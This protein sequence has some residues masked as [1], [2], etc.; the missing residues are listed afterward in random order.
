MVNCSRFCWK[1]ILSSFLP[2]A[3]ILGA[4]IFFI[5]HQESTRQVDHL[6]IHERSIA[7]ITTMAVSMELDTLVLSL[8]FLS[9]HEAL[10]SLR[11]KDSKFSIESLS[12]E[13]TRFLD[14]S[15][16][17]DQVKILDLSG[18]E[19]LRVNHSDKGSYVVQGSELQDKSG[20]EYFQQA[21]S[22][23]SSQIYISGMDL[24]IEQGRVKEPFKP[25][26]RA[27]V[28]ING[29]D[30]R[31]N[32][33]LV[34]IYF[35]QEIL[36]K[37]S[38]VAGEA[39]EKIM[40]LNSD[41]Q[42]FLGGP[43]GCNWSFMFPK[44]D[45]CYFDQRYPGDWGKIITNESG[46]FISSNG[47]FTFESIRMPVT[48][49]KAAEGN[50]VFSNRDWKLVSYV[51]M[52]GIWN[53]ST[54]PYLIGATSYIFI[55]LV[56]GFVSAALFRVKAEQDLVVESLHENEHRLREAEKIANLGSWEYDYIT[57]R[58]IWSDQTFRIFGYEPGEVKP[59]WLRF[60]K[61]VV[62]DDRQETI[63]AVPP[64]SSINAINLGIVRKDGVKCF[65]RVKR[66]LIE[67]N[68]KVV[69]ELGTIHDITEI[70]ERSDELGRLWR[71]IEHCPASIVITDDSGSVQYINPYFTELT[72]YS[73]SD[74]LGKNP[75]ILQ[76]GIHTK[77]FYLEMWSVLLS[78]KIWKGE[79]C[80][81]KK[82]GGIFWESATIAP[83]V[84]HRGTTTHYIGI[85]EDITQKRK[86]DEILRVSLQ[87]F[88]AL[89]ENSSIGI[90]Y[91][92]SGRSFHRVNNRFCDIVGY[93]QDDL[94]G[95]S[96]QFLYLSDKKFQE[97]WSDVKD[98]LISG[99]IVQREIE[100]R[101]KNSGMVWGYITGKAVSPP[102][103]E[104]GIIWTV[105][106]ISS[107]KDLE[108]LR[109]DV[110][111]IMRHDLKAPLNG[112]I[113]LPDL[114]EAE[115]NLTDDQKE[116]LGLIKEAGRRMLTQINTSLNLYKIETGSFNYV[117]SPVD[118]A[119]MLMKMIK[120]LGSFIAAKNLSIAP[121]L[122]DRKMTEQDSFLVKGRSDFCHSM[123]SNMLK[124]ACEAS[125]VGGLIIVSIDK[126]D[127]PRVRIYNKGV[128]PVE[129]RDVFFEK[130][131]TAGKNNGLGLGSYS[132]RMLMEAQLGAI[133]METS[134]E[135]T[136]ITFIFKNG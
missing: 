129:L 81:K 12:K 9:G 11:D 89:F 47:L 30:G 80:N 117:P 23:P 100:L 119:K 97:F 2:A 136:T 62:P 103:L 101:N 41:G 61:H 127:F 74:I 79:M 113:N 83:V 135:G 128:V 20:C 121:L 32:G 57:N 33:F 45:Q 96:S 21:L 90:A 5:A 91:M 66:R 26:I 51:S 115:G 49:Q 35:G 102:D 46:Q 14:S 65:L 53:A 125:P 71:A 92:K 67:K 87:E 40:L 72:G 106:D 118:I 114:I 48:A 123:F 28:P 133:E 6:K 86:Q 109:E 15:H 82:N 85:K 126:T 3:L 94:L 25:V 78:G 52:S 64:G 98:N 131:T 59:S 112:I 93:S 111:R 56:Y 99:K 19:I 77:E 107:R 29:V 10:N 73:S 108:K 58:L 39:Y 8:K 27:A 22:T 124:N 31:N 38:S 24:N 69:R 4:V 44:Q 132:A 84:N 13:F 54:F 122:E 76:S 120:E 105:D 42:W 55:L 75:R 95:K 34:V 60:L 116:N 37:I 7:K 36:K 110:D 1:W 130:Y 16:K 43:G 17:F 104:A 134:D 18:N 70:R 88:E 63:K 50:F 68:G